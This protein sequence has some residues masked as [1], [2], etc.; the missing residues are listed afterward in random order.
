MFTYDKR[1][2]EVKEC[3][4]LEALAVNIKGRERFPFYTHMNE[5]ASFIVAISSLEKYEQRRERNIH[6]DFQQFVV[7][8]EN[9]LRQV[10]QLH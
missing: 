6:M 3:Y 10:A 7:N 1:L 8:C 5:I 2:L 9:A 4:A